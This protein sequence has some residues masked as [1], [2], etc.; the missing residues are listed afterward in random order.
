MRDKLLAGDR[1]VDVVATI[2]RNI[3]FSGGE[4]EEGERESGGINGMK[5]TK[6]KEGGNRRKERPRGARGTNVNKQTRRKRE[7]K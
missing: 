4:E 7:K 3:A 1:E 5:K 2:A 6:R